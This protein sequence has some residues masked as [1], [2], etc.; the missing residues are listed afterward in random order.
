MKMP[1]LVISKINTY[2]AFPDRSLKPIDAWLHFKIIHRNSVSASMYA[3][4]CMERSHKGAYWYEFNIE[5]GN[6][7][8]HTPLHT[9]GRRASDS[10]LLLTHWGRVMPTCVIKLTIIGSDNGL[11]PSWHQAC[12]SQCSHIVVWK[13]RNKLQ[14]NLQRNSCTFHSWKL[15][16]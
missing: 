5:S 13:L 16:R 15:F 7:M 10:E 9:D 11:S 4:T 14:R 2:R 8:P 12:M 6:G 3:I 1:S